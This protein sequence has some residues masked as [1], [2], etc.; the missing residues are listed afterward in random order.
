MKAQKLAAINDM[1][2]PLFRIMSVYN[3]NEPNRRQIDN[4]IC[5]FHIGN[6]YILSVAHA[7][8][9]E[10]T[11][12]RS[13]TEADYQAT[14]MPHLTDA[15]ILQFNGW[16]IPD[17]ATNKRYLNLANQNDYTL[18][19]DILKRINYD[20]RIETLYQKNI[21][22]PYLIIQQKAAQFY[23]DAAAHARFPPSLTFLDPNSQRQTYLIEIELI[24]AFTADDV[25][26]YR[27]I[28][29]HQSIIDLIPFFEIDNEIYD[30]SEKDFYCL[31]SAPS[32][33]TPGRLLNVANIEGFLDQWIKQPDR[34]GGNYTL[35]GLR[36][37]IK[38]YFRFGS[39]GA[40]YLKFDAATNVFKVN[41]IQSEACPI[42][43]TINDNRNGNFQWINAIAT[44]LANVIDRINAYKVP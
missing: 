6:G 14:I 20:T 43:L 28:N 41:A 38:G 3:E 17:N 44:P 11:I 31:Q 36:Y 29:T 42:Q 39:S 27:I 7:L 30:V 13:M 5:A 12:F 8:K 24:E 21:C 32:D 19:V 15:E 22:K 4:D 37:L 16:Y 2:S 40:P 26:L 25:A 23:N 34:I 33:L 1:T 10:L 9:G 35:E 18:L